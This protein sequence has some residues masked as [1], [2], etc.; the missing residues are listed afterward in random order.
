MNPN[1][2]IGRIMQRLERFVFY[3]PKTFL[4]GMLLIT[5]FFATRVPYVQMY[6]D[7]ADLLPQKHPYIQL[8]NEIRD[9]FGGANNVIVAI[10]A[11]DGDIVNSDTLARVHEMTQGVDE[12]RAALVA[13]SYAWGVHIDVRSGLQVSDNYFDLLPH[14]EKVITVRGLPERST[15]AVQSTEKPAG[16]ARPAAL[17]DR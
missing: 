13:D 12:H 10:V 11:R 9:T 15:L 3:H 1:S 16:A 8:H 14:Q 4:L 7:F 6:S 2:L 17:A 5:A